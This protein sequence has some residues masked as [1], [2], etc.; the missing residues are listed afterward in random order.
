[1][2]TSSAL[3][4]NLGPS[5]SLSCV[6]AGLHGATLLPLWWAGLP[7]WTGAILALAIIVHGGWSV[8]RH[9]LLRSARS[10]TAVELGP[11]GNC[12]LIR[13]DGTEVAGAVDPGSLVVGALVI[14]GVR[15]AGIRPALRALIVRDM[16]PE[17]EFRRLRV[18][19]KWGGAQAPD[20]GHA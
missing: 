19:L 18:G 2:K 8:R 17:E 12:T 4:V 16:L 9:A 15:R 11:A 3:R 13:R 14:L 5:R 1:M 7:V 6:L 10:V 20:A